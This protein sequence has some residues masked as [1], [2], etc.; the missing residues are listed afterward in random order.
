MKKP[1]EKSSEEQ[2]KK[3]EILTSFAIRKPGRKKKAK[4]S[5]SS[6]RGAKRRQLEREQYEAFLQSLTSVEDY[7]NESS[8]TFIYE[9]L[10]YHRRTMFFNR[11]REIDPEGLKQFF[12]L[13]RNLTNNKKKQER[14][15]TAMS[16]KER[17]KIIKD[18][19]V[20]LAQQHWEEEGITQFRFVQ[21]KEI[22]NVIATL[23]AAGYSTHEVREKLEV[24]ID[25]INQVTP[26][27]VKAQ[28]KR[29]Q[30]AIVMA[31]DQK[32]YKDLMEDNVNKT[33]VAA[34]QIAHRRRKLVLDV[35][36]D[37]APK[38][39]GLL[40]SEIEEKEKNYADRFGVER[41]PIDVEPE[42]EKE[43]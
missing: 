12:A 10:T 23:L 16:K 21:P 42:K 17:D 33:T 37:K 22:L 29:F 27:M 26:E 35:M 34:D 18:E 31:A 32:V 9:K 38:G 14:I 11:I 15:S 6:S 25:L 2:D 8:V 4:Q 20:A 41:K 1:L 36:G 5:G 40:P 43:E 30:E 7:L 3:E 28:R 24:S 13:R 39:K 19:A